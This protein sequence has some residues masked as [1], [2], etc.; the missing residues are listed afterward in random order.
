LRG[1]WATEIEVFKNS[2][3]RRQLRHR[4]IPDADS[5]VERV[6]DGVKNFLDIRAGYFAEPWA[7]CQFFGQR[8]G[9]NARC[10]SLRNHQAVVAQKSS[11]FVQHAHD[12]LTRTDTS[13]QLRNADINLLRQLDLG[14][15]SV[16]ESDA[17]VEFQLVD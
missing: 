12:A 16:Q 9:G 7:R 14:G 6:T 13:E 11:R 1:D 8:N 15:V 4:K 3:I 10:G 5:N 2:W 17:V